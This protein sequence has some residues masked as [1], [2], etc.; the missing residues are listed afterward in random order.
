MIEFW[1]K[2]LKANVQSKLKDFIKKDSKIQSLDSIQFQRFNLGF[3]YQVVF[4]LQIEY[5]HANTIKCQG[6]AS[7]WVNGVQEKLIDNLRFKWVKS[8]WFFETNIVAKA[9]TLAVSFYPTWYNT[10]SSSLTAIFPSSFTCSMWQIAASVY[11]DRTE[12]SDRFRKRL[13]STISSLVS[14]VSAYENDNL[15]AHTL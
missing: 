1:K 15:P 2:L 8:Y 11:I 5:E 6:L 10:P 4:R 14:N 12:N 13:Y 9:T 3:G 7:M